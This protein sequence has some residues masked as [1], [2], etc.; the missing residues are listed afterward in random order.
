M[1]T[2]NSR[3]MESINLCMR[4]APIIQL[5]L[6]SSSEGQLIVEQYV[7]GINEKLSQLL[8]MEIP[9][10]YSGLLEALKQYL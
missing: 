7:A 5:G 6:I 8:N 4:L 2:L 1:N 3:R 10:E 9:C